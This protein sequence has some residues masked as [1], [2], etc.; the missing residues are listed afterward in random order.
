MMS[1]TFQVPSITLVMHGVPYEYTLDRDF[2][3]SAEY[4][5]MVSLGSKISPVLKKVLM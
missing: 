2:V 4:K 3:A 5:A 1:I